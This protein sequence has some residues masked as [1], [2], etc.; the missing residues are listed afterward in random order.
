MKE[1]TVCG[2]EVNR[3]R[4]LLRG[5]LEYVDFQLAFDMD[6]AAFNNEE[7]TM[8]HWKQSVCTSVDSWL[9]KFPELKSIPIMFSL[10][11][12]NEGCHIYLN[13]VPEFD[14]ILHF[15]G[16]KQQGVPMLKDVVSHEFPEAVIR[17]VLH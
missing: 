8:D 3:A 1:E 7:P 17:P 4:L 6:L 12:C 16:L 9:V 14:A 13:A 5:L 2:V 10:S 15:V 11:S